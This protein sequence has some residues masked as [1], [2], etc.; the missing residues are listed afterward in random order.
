MVVRG[1]MIWLGW[2]QGE[3]PV[4]Q[5]DFEKG[6]PGPRRP[7]VNEEPNDK[8]LLLVRSWQQPQNAPRHLRPGRLV[9]DG[10]RWLGAG[11]TGLRLLQTSTAE[12]D[13][14]ATTVS[15]VVGEESH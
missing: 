3:R 4:R 13:G 8:P 15:A 1:C 5:L 7:R 11:R 2:W 14:A 6:R 10:H 12:A 9:E